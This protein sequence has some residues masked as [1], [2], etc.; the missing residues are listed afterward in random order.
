MSTYRYNIHELEK[1]GTRAASLHYRTDA[2]DELTLTIIP[3][4]YG[5]DFP[6]SPLDRVELFAVVEGQCC[7]VFS[8]VVPMRGGVALSGGAA[9][10]MQLRACSDYYLLGQTVYAKVDAATGTAM[11]EQDAELVPLGE[12]ARKIFNWASGWS[13][14]AITSGLTVTSGLGTVPA[15]VSSGS[16]SCA[17]MIE[18]ALQWQPD[19]LI[20]QRYDAENG[21]RLTLGRPSAYPLLTLRRKE[22]LTDIAVTPRSD[23]VPP[24]CALVGAVHGVW[25]AGA[26]VRRPGAFVYA[27]PRASVNSPAAESTG[28]GCG[29]NPGGQ[30]MVVR[31]YRLP[32]EFRLSQLSEYASRA[33]QQPT[34]EQK[35]ILLRYFPQ[36][37]P[38][39]SYLLVSEGYVLPLA[40]EDA[41][42]TPEP[43][44]DEQEPIVPANYSTQLENWKATGVFIHTSG[45]F[46]A[47]TDARKNVSGLK[48]C[49][50]QLVLDVALK[51]D[52]LDSM[53]TTE[54]EA[55]ERLLP[56]TRAVTAAG[57]TL[58]RW[59]TLRLTCNLINRSRKCYSTADNKLLSIDPDFDAEQENEQETLRAL[60]YIAA[61]EEYYRA[62]RTVWSEG[63]VGL[64]FDGSRNPA[65]MTG[66]LLHVEGLAP[67]WEQMNATIRTVNWDLL[68][69]SLNLE[70]GTREVLGFSERLERRNMARAAT[71]A[72]QR[73]ETMGVDSMDTAADAEQEV[74][75]TVA[76]DVATEVSAGVNGTRRKPFC[77]YCEGGKYYYTGGIFTAL[78]QSFEVPHTQF[79]IT[80]GKQTQTPL[81]AQPVKL[82]VLRVN[83]TLT[84]NLIQK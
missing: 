59:A 14:T 26:D 5:S 39:M 77:L 46:P 80:Q 75:M 3:T 71:Q 13:G 2:A 44:A 29:G 79:T 62:T 8:G 72:P 50:A 76:A 57:E 28:A 9:P 34:D 52:A 43:A 12:F 36:L 32:K 78:G 47:A 74:D 61:M 7:C 42:D 4:A 17:A 24:V 20:C 54:K 53:S 22:G 23:L 16:T 6:W 18:Q 56:G 70:F 68:G 1:L 10:T 65:A 27:V 73:R 67:E 25:P 82:Q 48:W 31:G 37:E 69:G 49:K 63:S 11:A 64:R 40:A 45:E 60:T 55:A 33:L 41:F 83:G 35:K 84:Y 21:H 51:P 30:K 81:T 66:R 15:P 58:R 19:A 38:L